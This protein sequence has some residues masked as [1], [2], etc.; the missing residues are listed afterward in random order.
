MEVENVFCAAGAGAV[1]FVS[2]LLGFL[3]RW[4]VASAV[5]RCSVHAC[6]SYT[7]V[8]D[9]HRSLRDGWKASV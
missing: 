5:C 2:C 4:V 3:V 1:F 7:F 8:W 9:L 6:L